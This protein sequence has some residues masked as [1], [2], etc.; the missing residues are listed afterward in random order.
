MSG[1][2][3][4]LALAIAVGLVGIL[5]PLLPGSLLVLGA[6]GVW[7][8]TEGDTTGWAVLVGTTL[9]IAA[10]AVVKYLIPGRRLQRDGVPN[11]SLF[12]GACSAWLGSS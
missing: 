7:A 12:A 10:G 1:L 8:L 3:I 5:V 4:L 11:R 6:I 2:E 9:L